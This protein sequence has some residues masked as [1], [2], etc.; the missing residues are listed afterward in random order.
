MARLQGAA[1]TPTTDFSPAKVRLQGFLPKKRC[2]S[3][4]RRGLSPAHKAL[5][6]CSAAAIG[7][8]GAP[9]THSD[10]LQTAFSV[11]A[12]LTPRLPPDSA[13]RSAPASPP[14]TERAPPTPPT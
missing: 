1:T 13:N 5:L 12:N 3:P 6:P 7:P 8:R 10:D 11:T 4:P 2:R 14:P 9:W